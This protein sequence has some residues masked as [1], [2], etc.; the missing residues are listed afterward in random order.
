MTEVIKGSGIQFETRISEGGNRYIT[1]VL[2]E[3]NS[4][5]DGLMVVSGVALSL[6]GSLLREGT[7][8]PTAVD[9]QNSETWDNF[10]FYDVNHKGDFMIT[11]NTNGNSR[12]TNFLPIRAAY[13]CAKEMK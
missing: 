2:L 3:A 7:L 9:G 4:D 5:L 8:I 11:G 1:E 6:G 10:D 12:P 13:S